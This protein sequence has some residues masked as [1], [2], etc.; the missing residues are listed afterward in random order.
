MNSIFSS[1]NLILKSYILV[2]DVIVS[3]FL[4]LFVFKKINFPA[5]D[6]HL[7]GGGEGRGG[8]GGV[9]LSVS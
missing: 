8:E 4:F 3:F 6:W 7:G 9:I 2:F 1:E 5:M